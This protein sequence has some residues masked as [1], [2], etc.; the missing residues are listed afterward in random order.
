MFQTHD[1]VE[2]LAMM[3][4]TLGRP[5][6]NF[7]KSCQHQF[8]NEEFKLKWDESNQDGQFVRSNCKVR[9]FEIYFQTIFKKS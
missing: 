3:E 9:L 2:H 8:Y 6:R 7:V 1:N 4:A 5:P